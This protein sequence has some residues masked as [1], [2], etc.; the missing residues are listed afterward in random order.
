MKLSKEN[1][2]GD[3]TVE[4]Y[5]NVSVLLQYFIGSITIYTLGCRNL[6]LCACSPGSRLTCDSYSTEFVY[7]TFPF[8]LYVFCY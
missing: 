3:C 4:G 1:G 8:Y 6:T 2:E 7:Y 5:A